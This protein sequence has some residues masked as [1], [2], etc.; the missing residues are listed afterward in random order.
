MFVTNHLQ[1]LINEFEEKNTLQIPILITILY[2]DKSTNLI[3]ETLPAVPLQ[4]GAD[5]SFL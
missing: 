2:T 3:D 4:T 5:G 1:P